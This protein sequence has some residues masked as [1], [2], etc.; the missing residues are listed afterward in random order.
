[1]FNDIPFFIAALKKFKCRNSCKINYVQIDCKRIPKKFRRLARD[2]SKTVIAGQMEL[3]V[4]PF[5]TTSMFS[6]T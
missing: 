1:M 4:Q 3:E 5:S 2:V 6:F